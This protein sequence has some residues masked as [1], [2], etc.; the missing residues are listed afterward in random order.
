MVKYIK[1]DNFGMSNAAAARK[2]GE[3][4]DKEWGAVD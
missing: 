1:K 2:E 4:L 3:E